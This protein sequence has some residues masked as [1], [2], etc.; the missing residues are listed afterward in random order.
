MGEEETNGQLVY[1]GSASGGC[2]GATAFLFV[3]VETFFLW[4]L[5]FFSLRSFSSFLLGIFLWSLFLDI[6]LCKCIRYVSLY[7]FLFKFSLAFSLKINSKFSLYVFLNVCL[8][9]LS[10]YLLIPHVF[11]TNYLVVC[12]PIPILFYLLVPLCFN[13]IISWS[14]YL[15]YPIVV[16]ENDWNSHIY[17]SPFLTWLPFLFFIFCSF[18]CFIFLYFS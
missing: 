4:F 15:F 9:E 6:F 2:I 3:L 12:L 1:D 8:H 5:V 7:N 10:P 14:L 13:L 16:T 18:N 11:I 17:F